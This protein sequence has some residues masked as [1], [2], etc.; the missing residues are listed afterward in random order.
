MSLYIPGANN[1]DPFSE[2]TFLS[3]LIFLINPRKIRIHVFFGGGGIL[4]DSAVMSSLLLHVMHDLEIQI[5]K[6]DSVQDSRWKIKEKFVGKCFPIFSRAAVPRRQPDA[7]VGAKNRLTV[8][9]F[10]SDPR[11]QVRRSQGPSHRHASGVVRQSFG[12][13]RILN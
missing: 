1:L 4:R 7:S 5:A 10:T 3:A 8:F 11:F 9:T 13:S 6:E 2:Y 12:N